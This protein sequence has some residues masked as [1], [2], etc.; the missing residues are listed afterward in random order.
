VK[1]RDEDGTRAEVVGERRENRGGV[2]I[3]EKTMRQKRTRLRSDLKKSTGKKLRRY[4]RKE[5]IVRYNLP[6]WW[7]GKG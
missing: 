5:E 1:E 2:N 3:Q 4:R 6:G 7:R